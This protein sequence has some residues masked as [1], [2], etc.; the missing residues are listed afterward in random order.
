[1]ENPGKSP[2]LYKCASLLWKI[3]IFTMLNQR[4]LCAMA[5]PGGRRSKSWCLRH[6]GAVERHQLHVTGELCGKVLHQVVAGARHGGSAQLG[7]GE[8]DCYYNVSIIWEMIIIIYYNIYIYLII[9][10]YIV[11]I[12]IFI[13][14]KMDPYNSNGSYG[15]SYGSFPHSPSTRF[16][17]GSVKFIVLGVWVDDDDFV[18]IFAHQCLFMP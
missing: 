17:E 9:Y 18:P 1:M 11:Y 10:I 12:Y 2:S 4:V 7:M 3:T 5:R 14:V 8:W 6:R 16:P 13:I 15:F